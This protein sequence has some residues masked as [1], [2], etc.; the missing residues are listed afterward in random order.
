MNA[1][2]N[3]SLVLPWAPRGFVHGKCKGVAFLSMPLFF[4]SIV[5]E[6]VEVPGVPCSG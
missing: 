4:I 5:S 6:T 3:L 1:R 2:N